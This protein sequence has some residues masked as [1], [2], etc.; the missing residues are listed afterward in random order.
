MTES[1]QNRNLRT[2]RWFDPRLRQYSFR[3]LMRVVAK[4]FI[5][6]SLLSVVLTI[7]MWE[8]SQWLGKKIVWSTV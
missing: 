3:G 2:G 4:G 7:V 8:N 5:P 6:L 1:S